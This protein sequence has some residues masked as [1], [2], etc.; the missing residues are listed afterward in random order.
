M[1]VKTKSIYEPK[2]SSDGLRI[3]VSRYYPRGIKRDHFDL[4]LIDASPERSLLKSYKE[5]SISWSEFTA[6]FS[7]Q[8]RISM[9]SK[10]AMSRL[11]ELCRSKRKNVTLLC[12]E[13]EGKHCHRQIVKKKLEFLMKTR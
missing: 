8:L 11:V 10:D 9:K 13:K 1:K 2:N 12:Y 7:R 6:L 3:L 4:W 5:G